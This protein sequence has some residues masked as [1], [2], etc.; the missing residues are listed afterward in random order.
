M[1]YV[2]L[3]DAKKATGQL[4]REA[5]LARHYTQAQLAEMLDIEQPYI[6]DLERGVREPSVKLF[7]AIMKK[8]KVHFIC[9]PELEE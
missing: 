7:L 3:A 5:R 8:C 2:V 4:I 1:A 6:S 9:S